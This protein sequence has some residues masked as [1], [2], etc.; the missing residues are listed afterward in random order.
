M[1]REL[2]KVEID[3]IPED[4]LVVEVRDSDAPFAALLAAATDRDGQTSG[5]ARLLVERWPERVDVTGALTASVPMTCV[6]CLNPFTW[7]AA[8]DVNQILLR[9]PEQREDEET[10]LTASDLDRTELA[11][12]TVDL[13]ELLHEE[14]LL[15]LPVKPLCAESC[16]GIC[17]GCGAELNEEECT[18][19]PEVDPRW[20]VLKGLK[21][22]D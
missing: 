21:L 22:G 15:A 18:C 4:G 13:A 14:L 2:L 16:K 10:E 3:A 20:E 17:P 19:E 12:D 1:A 5:S 6:R 8:R 9:Q 7:Q 11:G